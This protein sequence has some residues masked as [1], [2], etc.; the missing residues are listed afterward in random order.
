MRSTM[1]STKFFAALLS[2]LAAVGMAADKPLLISADKIYAD[3]DAAPLTN[4][5]VLIRGGRIASVADERA[6][7]ALPKG[8]QTSDCRGVVVAGFQN[9]HVHFTEPVWNEAAHAPREQLS[10]A[11]QAMLTKYGFT[12]VF[13]T[14]SDQA[15]TVALRERIRRHEVPGPRILTVGLPLFPV[16]GIPVYIRDLPAEVLARMHQ[17]GNAAEA[18]AA[19]RANLANGADG[20][21]LFLHTSPDG[22]SPR[23]MSMEVIRAAVEETHAHG[24]LV[25]AHPTSLEAIRSG[26]AAGV[27]VFVHTTLGEK[28]PW[29]AAVVAQMKQQNV[30]VIP[31]FELWGYEL[32]KQSVPPTV[33]DALVGATLDELRAFHSAGGQVLFGTDVGYMHLYDPTEEYVLMQKAG[34]SATQILASLTTAPAAR[35]KDV[36]RGRVEPGY[37]ADLVVLGGDPADDVKNFANV[38]CVFRSG[39]LIYSSKAH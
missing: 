15:N 35:W 4:G 21:K 33:I 14:G 20:T 27:D 39:E 24:K 31:T 11:L 6:R 29:D 37:Q 23:F 22:Q 25:L 7:I 10:L 1:R 16:D 34:M 13:D 26:L 30:S 8:T 28:A 19:V 36:K 18:R 17:P 9:S 5:A 32:R 3:P 38:S 12:T 2:S